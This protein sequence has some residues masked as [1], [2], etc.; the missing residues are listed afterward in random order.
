ML[1]SCLKRHHGFITKP[2]RPQSPRQTRHASD[3]KPNA[4]LRS[5]IYTSLPTP[6]RWL[7]DRSHSIARGTT[8]GIALFLAWHIEYSYFFEYNGCH[9]ISM[10]PTFNSFGDA[11][12]ISK[13]HRRGRGVNVGDLVSFA[14]P[15]DAEQRAI[16]RVLGM[17]GDFVCR[18]TPGTSGKMLQV[19]SRGSK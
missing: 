15:V 3:S 7:L 12:L 2:A 8:I 17:P 6:L 10:L 11:V 9:G 16:K 4:P 1:R 13:Y 18:D 19:S 14:H 5:R